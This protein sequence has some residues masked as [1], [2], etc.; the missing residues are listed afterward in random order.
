MRVPDLSIV[1]LTFLTHLYALQTG[2]DPVFASELRRS[3]SESYKVAAG[4]MFYQ[5]LNRLVDRG[6]VDKFESVTP[7]TEKLPAVSYL[8]TEAGLES[9]EDFRVWSKIIDKLI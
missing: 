7:G 5:V 4:P 1:Q 9:I 3:V 6:I 2:G 8:L